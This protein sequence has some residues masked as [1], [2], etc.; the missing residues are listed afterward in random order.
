MAL[1]LSRLLRLISRE[2]HTV[3]RVFGM[4]GHLREMIT[5]DIEMAKA[6]IL[7]VPFPAPHRTEFGP[8]P[9]LFH[10]NSQFFFAVNHIGQETIVTG[11]LESVVEFECA[12]ELQVE[13]A[14]EI[15]E[16]I[17]LELRPVPLGRCI[18]LLRLMPGLAAED[19]EKDSPIPS[20]RDIL[21]YNEIRHL[22]KTEALSAATNDVFSILE[23]GAWHNPYDEEVREMAAV[24]QGD[25]ELL[26][27]ILQESYRGDVGF[28][29]DNALRHSK[30]L[31]IVI[32]TIASR[33][34]IRGGVPYEVAF[35]M[36][37]QFIAQIEQAKTSAEANNL[38][39]TAEFLYARTA[40][41]YRSAR[42]PALRSG[43]NEH[44]ERCKNYIFQ[45]LH[46]KIRVSEISEHLA[47][48]ANYLSTIFRKFEGVTIGEY[49]LR[50]K[51]VLVKNMLIYSDYSFLEITNYFGFASQS[52]LGKKFKEET[53]MTLREYR[54]RFRVREFVEK[55]EGAGS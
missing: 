39:R 30:N 15:I 4:D 14:P 26:R 12:K 53:G 29:A 32:I 45:H 21:E 13:M 34:A 41:D 1:S 19:G 46:G 10:I 27:N 40:R 36:S 3:I 47:L 33:A 17:S 55:P 43:E 54:I 2:L 50:Q 22:L 52:Y 28:L 35:S 9:A 51:L 37:D 49:I 16:E 23:N 38:A 8:L 18:N 20:L 31:A 11:P 48:N 25:P 6:E 42:K 44:V 7:V 24:E 5:E